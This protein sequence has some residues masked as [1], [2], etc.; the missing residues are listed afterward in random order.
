MDPLTLPHQAGL[1]QDAEPA[2]PARI[3]P[4]G[5]IALALVAAGLAA[6]WAWHGAGMELFLAGLG[7]FCL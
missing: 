4:E 1:A 3:R 7:G 6:A 2:A 5:W